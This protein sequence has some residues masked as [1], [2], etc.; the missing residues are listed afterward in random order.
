MMQNAERLPPAFGQCKRYLSL[1]VSTVLDF[2][3]DNYTRGIYIVPTL[4][5][6]NMQWEPPTSRPNPRG[7]RGT[8]PLCL[9]GGTILTKIIFDPPL[10]F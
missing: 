10:T 1:P 8:Q 4:L 3:R 5:L 2:H 7:S 9:E 6:V